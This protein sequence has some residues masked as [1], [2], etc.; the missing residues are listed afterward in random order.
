MLGLCVLHERAFGTAGAGTPIVGTRSGTG[1]GG[2]NGAAAGAAGI[3]AEGTGWTGST[4]E[5]GV[6]ID[7]VAK[8]SAVA[9][10]TASSETRSG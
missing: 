9:S 5:A 7:D 2:T 3:A 8:N 1:A 4:A 6:A 10:L